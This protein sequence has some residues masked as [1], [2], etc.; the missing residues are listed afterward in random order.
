LF[1][2]EKKQKFTAGH[3]K[4]GWSVFGRTE[5]IANATKMKKN[6]ILPPKKNNKYA[7]LE[8]DALKI[9]KFFGAQS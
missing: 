6:L 7:G 2:I 3:K 8:Y 1:N 4:Q 5:K 9:E